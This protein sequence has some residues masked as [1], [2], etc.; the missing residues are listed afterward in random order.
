MSGDDG[1][2]KPD[3]KGEDAGSEPIEINV[4][5][6]GHEALQ[7]RIKK[8][9]KMSKVI[10]AYCNVGIPRRLFLPVSSNAA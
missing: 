1:E 3:V 9:T 8:K 5:R 2:R 10:E 6:E 7:F 4:Q